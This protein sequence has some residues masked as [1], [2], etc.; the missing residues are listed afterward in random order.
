MC[1]EAIVAERDSLGL[2]AEDLIARLTV[3]YSRPLNRY[4]SMLCQYI[5]Q[6]ILICQNQLQGERFEKQ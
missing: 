3:G 2:E 1:F 6:G 5:G 4:L